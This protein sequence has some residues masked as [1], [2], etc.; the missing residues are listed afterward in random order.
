DK[1]GVF[2]FARLMHPAAPASTKD[3]RNGEGGAKAQAAS[4]TASGMTDT[5]TA[6]GTGTESGKDSGK[7]VETKTAETPAPQ[8]SSAVTG[9]PADTSSVTPAPAAVP[10]N[11]ANATAETAGAADAGY[12]SVLPFRDVRIDRV[13]VNNGALRFTDRSVAPAFASALTELYARLDGVSLAPD[14]RPELDITAKL[15]N[16]AL[17]L[18]GV[19]N[20]IITPMYSDV[21]FT[22]NGVDLV[23]LSPYSLR[24]VAYPIEK[25]RLYADV[26]VKT[27]NWMLNA[28]NKLFLEQIVMGD[29]DKRPD[30]PSIPIKLGLALLSD[31]SG[32][33]EIDLPINGRLDDPHFLTG[34]IVFKAFMNLIF[35]VVTSPFALIGNIVGGGGDDAQFSV[36]EAGSDRLT[37]G[38]LQNLKGVVDFMNKKSSLKLE[39]SGFVDQQ[40]DTKGLIEL[41]LRRRVQAAKYADMSRRERAAIV[42]ED[43]VITPEEYAEYLTDAYKEVPEMENDPRPAGVFGFKEVPVADMEAFLRSLTTVTPQSLTELAA[44]RAKAV[45]AAVLQIDPALAP[46]VFLTGAGKKPTQKTGV[47]LHR[48]ELGVR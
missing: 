10:G 43:V 3:G 44:A 22:M 5:A 47:P 34:G 29:K 31:S 39:I 37:E 13:R 9:S 23:P 35:K 48:V 36:F 12:A 2:N 41:G 14:A 20:P 19:A 40:A 28:N 30:A 15:D 18:K 16:Q 26:K 17:A 6:G 27:E 24:S 32:N 46:R 45:Q 33:V 8:A 7:P 38:Q 1:D 21:T 11:A 42:M 4:G 25:G